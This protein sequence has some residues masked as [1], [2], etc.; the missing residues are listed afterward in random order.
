M[1][2]D[3]IEARALRLPLKDRAALA[4]KLISSLDSPNEIELEAVVDKLKLKVTNLPEQALA[5]AYE[6][7]ENRQKTRNLPE[8]AMLIFGVPINFEGNIDSLKG[9]KSFYNALENADLSTHSKA[10][11][12]RCRRFTTMVLASTVKIDEEVLTRRR[13]KVSIEAD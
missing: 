7:M 11:A 6:A 5:R 12:D 1:N 2:T 9:F 10:K 8:L 3:T 13:K 4:S